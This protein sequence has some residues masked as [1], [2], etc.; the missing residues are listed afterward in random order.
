MGASQ[1]LF[2]VCSLGSTDSAGQ[3]TA[4]YRRDR[5]DHFQLN[6]ITQRQ[7]ILIVDYILRNTDF[8]VLPNECG[9]MKLVRLGVLDKAYPLHDVTHVQRKS[10]MITNNTLK[11]KKMG[12]RQ[13]L[14]K[15]WAQ[16]DNVLRKQPLDEIREYFGE[17]V[18]LYFAF[19]GFYTS[20]L[21]IF[22]IMGSIVINYGFLTVKTSVY[23]N[24]MC[25]ITRVMCPSCDQHC[26]YWHFNETCDQIKF[27]YYFDN[28]SNLSYSFIISIWA[29]AFL[30]F[31]KRQNAKLDHKWDLT[32]QDKDQEPIRPEYRQAAGTKQRINP[33]TLEKEPYVPGLK[34]LKR[35][36]FSISFVLTSIALVT[37]TVFAVIIYR[38][39]SE[40]LLSDAFQ[41]GHGEHDHEHDVNILFKYF[42]PS[43]ISSVS[44]SCISLFLIIVLNAIYTVLAK[45][46]T[47]FE[48]PRTEE[49][50][51]NSLALKVFAFQFVNFY[52]PLFYIAFFKETMSGHPCTYS[53]LGITSIKRLPVTLS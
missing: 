34:R 26:N 6:Q 16:Y 43:L 32:R 9:V 31:W 22:S 20:W 53:I 35:H 41:D 21:T 5:S 15:Y 38:L 28:F 44:A 7:R 52:S 29:M 14:D 50:Y 47:N 48:L 8:G 40:S 46:I 13:K 18:A 49:E 45:Y 36:I 19:C 2:Q 4:T 10:S 11:V 51:E 25:N 17:K 1:C 42:S 39:A 23:T 37:G 27:I 33:V 3:Y 30:Q 24:E 12:L